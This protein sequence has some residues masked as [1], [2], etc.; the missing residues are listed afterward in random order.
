[1]TATLDGVPRKKEKLE[2]SPEQRAAE[3]LVAR[4]REQTG[5]DGLL[6]QLTKTVLELWGIR[7]DGQHYATRADA[8]QE[9]FA[10]AHRPNTNST[11]H[12]THS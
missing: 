9:I 8:R 10:T 6:K 7:V 4:A 12:R 11:S 3:D 1:M 2:P 5:P